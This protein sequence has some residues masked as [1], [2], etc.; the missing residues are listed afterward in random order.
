MPTMAAYGRTRPVTRRVA[1]GVTVHAVASVVSA[2]D[3][4]NCGEAYRLR[5]T[6][7]HE[8]PVAVDSQRKY[9]LI[10]G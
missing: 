2:A 1:K 8:Q 10:H 3:F 4:A 6:Q 7:R 5:R 9:R